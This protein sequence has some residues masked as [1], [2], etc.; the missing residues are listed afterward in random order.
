MTLLSKAAALE[1][2][3]RAYDSSGMYRQGRE[4]WAQAKTLRALADEARQYRNDNGPVL[5]GKARRVG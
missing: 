2:E 1:L 3:A 5:A 4:C